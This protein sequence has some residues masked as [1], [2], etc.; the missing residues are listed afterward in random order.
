MELYMALE[1][2]PERTRIGWIGTGVMGRSMCGHLIK[3]GYQVTLFTR[4][5][6]KAVDLMGRG[7]AWAGSPREVAAGS[8][9][10]AARARETLLAAALLGTLMLMRVAQTW[11][12]CRDFDRRL[13]T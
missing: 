3:A 10:V 6:E 9:V 5:K 1:I 11:V 13:S 2:S 7:A 12:G 8:D 4:T